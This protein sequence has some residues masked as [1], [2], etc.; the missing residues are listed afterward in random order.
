[1]AKFTGENLAATMGAASWT[2]ITSIDISEN[3]DVYTAACAGSSYKSRAVGTIDATITVNYIADTAGS[4]QT[5]HRPGTSGTFTCSL[6]AT[7]SAQY[8]GAA[9]IESHNVSAPVE[10]FVTGTVVIGIDGALTVS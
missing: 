6:N 2:C 8:S 10:G 4:E 1:M 3:A 5:D 7:A 9:I